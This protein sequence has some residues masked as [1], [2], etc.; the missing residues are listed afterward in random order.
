M[1]RVAIVIVSF[2]TADLL[3]QCLESIARCESRCELDVIVV[4]NGSRDGSA[5]RVA[6]RYPGVHL[7]RNAENLGF[8]KAT[9]QGI[10]ITDADYVLLLNSDTVVLP[11]AIDR[12]V[13][14]LEAH[15]A[16]GIAGC[17]VLKPD[18][19]LDAPCRRSFPTPQNAFY[20]R[21]GLSRLFPESR[22]FGAYYVSY[23][24]ANETASVDCLM[25]A[26][27]LIRRAVI[28]QI[29]LLDEDCFFYAEDIDYCYRAKQAGWDVVYYPGAT[30]IHHRGAS[31]A[32]DR[33][34]ATTYFHRSMLVYYRKHLAP[35]RSRLVNGLVYSGIALSYAAALVWNKITRPRHARPLSNLREFVGRQQPIGQ[36]AGGVGT[37]VTPPDAKPDDADHTLVG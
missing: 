35:R 18:G 25:G 1:L 10:R 6:D 12:V 24:D 13:E 3:D 29:G 19:T 31:T 23:L 11:G 33:I 17:K 7:I 4:D 22:R 30:I 2:N 14:Y 36:R 37:R 26:Y 21:V 27:M 15:P 28:D 5:D 9:N 32:K 20:Q 8:S 34:K 16:A